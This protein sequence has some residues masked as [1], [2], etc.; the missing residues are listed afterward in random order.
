EF[1]IISVQELDN[2]NFLGDTASAIVLFD[3]GSLVV[4]PGSVA[5]TTIKRHMRVKIIRK[6][7]FDEWGN[8]HFFVNKDGQLKIKAATYNLENGK[9][10]KS[11]MTDESVKRSKYNKD[12]EEISIAF[13]NVKVGSVIEFTYT[14]RD[15]ALFMPSWKFQHSIPT[16]WSE[17]SISVPIK[18]FVPHLRGPFKPTKHETKYEGKYQRWLMTD[19]PS[20]VPEPLMPDKDIYISAIEFAIKYISWSEIYAHLTLSVSFGEIIHKHKY[21]KNIVDEITAGYTEPRQKIKVISNY[22][23]KNVQFNGISDYYAIS[24]SDLLDKKTG[25]AGDINLLFASMLEKAGLKVNVVLL[26]TRSNG[27]ILEG[28]PSL[29]QFDYVI[30]EVTLSD[31]ELLVDATEKH[32]PF[33]L[34]PPRCFNH[35]GFLV[36][37]GQFGWI[38]IEPVQR[39]RITLEADLALTENGGVKGK[40]K[41]YKDGYA[42]FLARKKYWEEDRKDFQYF[43]P[44]SKVWTISKFEMLNMNI[45]DKTV[46]EN[47]DIEAESF[48]SLSDDLIYLNPHVFLREDIN[49]FTAVTRDYPIDFAYLTDNTVICNLTIPDGYMIEELP[50][51]KVIVLPGNA[52][53]CTF[54]VSQTGNK[55]MVMSKLQFNRTLFLPSEYGNLKEFYSRLVSKKSENIVFKR[56]P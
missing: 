34:L 14:E 39:E 16:R 25:S 44:E 1:G 3:K 49:P 46:I 43:F 20:F 26:S 11:E 29:S 56:K 31:G 15:P 2:Q 8:H 47:Y 54:S 23:K 6:E 18:E 55:I 38:S 13:P 21:L 10:Q 30:C 50:E 19:L 7:S 42:A 24:P 52:A 33:D 53:K 27:Y 12:T 22:I 4:D 5:G 9:I 51:N 36:G 32:L 17:Y 40:L 35:K 28:F 45:P 41:S 48:A 37:E